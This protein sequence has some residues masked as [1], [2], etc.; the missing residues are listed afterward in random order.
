MKEKFDLQHLHV[1]L[2]SIVGMLSLVYITNFQLFFLQTQS[3]KACTQITQVANTINLHPLGK[4]LF[5]VSLT[6]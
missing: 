1:F 3:T 6:T 4:M 2:C 5:A